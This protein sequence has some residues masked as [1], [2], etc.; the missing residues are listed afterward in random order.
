M[1]FGHIGFDVEDLQ[2]S[3]QFYKPIMNV[4]GLELKHDSDM[5]VRF[6][7]PNRTLF[8]F[9]KK[10]SVSGP[11]HIAFEVDTREEVDRFY[12]AALEGGGTDNG[13]PGVRERYS[14]TYYAAFVI[15]P[16]GNNIEVVCR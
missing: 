4:L 15:D 5:Q 2:K 14:P 9:N 10:N 11:F 1:K 6:G 3:A 12:K 7:P 13:A 8:Y 16:D